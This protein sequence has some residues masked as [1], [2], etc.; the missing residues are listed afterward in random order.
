MGADRVQEEWGSLQK[1]LRPE[2]GARL[3]MIALAADRD[4]VIPDGDPNLVRVMLLARAAFRQNEGVHQV[5]VVPA[6]WREKTF[7]AWRALLDAWLRGE[8]PLPIQEIV[9][10]SGCSYPTVAGM[11]DRLQKT[12]EIE[13]TRNR[14]ATFHSLP[15]RSLGEILTLSA[16]LRQ[17]VQFVDTSGRPPDP[18]GLLR[19]ISSNTR[20]VAVGGVVA[21]RHYTP[22]FDLNGLPRIDLTTYRGAPLDWLEKVDPALSLAGMQGAFSP[23]TRAAIHAVYPELKVSGPHQ[24]SP[25]LVI[26]R[27]SRGEPLLDPPNKGGLPWAGPAETLLDL[28]ELRLT[29]QAEEF[30]RAMRAKRERDV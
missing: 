13:R 9:K 15:R 20:N 22:N 28:L 7:E 21:A 10:R 3:K 27:T 12:G 29:S 5:D 6:P 2:I 1:I 16:D 23:E 24:R 8:D 25:I 30:V 18:S 4:V 17:T 26:H 14:S 19:R 11:L